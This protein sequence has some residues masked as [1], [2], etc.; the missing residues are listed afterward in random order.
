MFRWDKEKA[1]DLA[2]IPDM[3]ISEAAARLGISASSLEKFYNRNRAELT[4]AREEVAV[5]DRVYTKVMDLWGD[6]YPRGE[7][8]AKTGLSSAAVRRLLLAAEYDEAPADQ[9]AGL[10]LLALQTAHPDRFY[11]DDVRALTEYSRGR[12]P[13]P[14]LRA[15]A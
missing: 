3:T 10:E 11:E 9:G 5:P 15:A 2:C 13:V 4:A 14:E 6:N 8:A 1:I 7:I 12:K